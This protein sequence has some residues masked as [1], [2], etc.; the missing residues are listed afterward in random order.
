MATTITDRELA[1]LWERAAAIMWPQR[2]APP[3]PPAV[4][5]H[6]WQ[7][8]RYYRAGA[9]FRST[10]TGEIVEYYPGCVYPG[11]GDSRGTGRHRG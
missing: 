9:G 2:A 5:P 1:S 3:L 8:S 11:C 4:P 7:A 10:L 6:E